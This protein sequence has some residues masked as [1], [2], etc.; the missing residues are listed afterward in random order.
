MADTLALSP[1]P[2]PRDEAAVGNSPFPTVIQTPSTGSLNVGWGNDR[3][4]PTNK[5]HG[6]VRKRSA[7]P[8]P[9]LLAQMK[10]PSRRPVDFVPA[11]PST[12]EVIAAAPPRA[13]MSD[14]DIDASLVNII[15]DQKEVQSA[16]T[17][18]QA[19][20]KSS[21][22]ARATPAYVPMMRS[23]RLSHE[24]D[25]NPSRMS[26]PPSAKPP[27]SAQHEVARNE[28]T[29]PALSAASTCLRESTEG[30]SSELETMSEEGE[31][32]PSQ[33]STPGARARRKSR[34]KM[35]ERIA[36]NSPARQ[37][38]ASSPCTSPGPHDTSL[39]QL[40]SRPGT[41]EAAAWRPPPAAPAAEW[42]ANKRHAH[43]SRLLSASARASR[44][45]ARKML[46]MATNEQLRSQ[47][48]GEPMRPPTPPSPSDRYTTMAMTLP[49][50]H[51]SLAQHSLVMA[52]EAK[53]EEEAAAARRALAAR[54]EQWVVAARGEQM[55]G[56]PL[57]C[58]L[59]GVHAILGCDAGLVH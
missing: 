30:T 12:H 23:L 44:G 18:L 29:S 25:S 40:G 54:R 8:M 4:L 21:P 17:A 45:A 41:P 14:A 43:A 51:A 52:L 59:R 32:L 49:P 36:P 3:P 24:R 53:R 39:R 20:H 10:P 37:S 7:A 50:T 47:R 56:G 16:L 58:F 19:L 1:P 57:A 55:D 35:N 13:Q 6:F 38:G 33:P 2:E 15:S 48:A 28:A 31:P 27:R 9:N 11:T 5:N 34:E 42:E 22:P 46:A 26:T